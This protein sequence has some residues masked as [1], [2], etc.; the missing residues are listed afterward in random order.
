M[1]S[2]ILP[3]VTCLPL[4]LSATITYNWN[5]TW[6]S[7]APDG[8]TRPVI[9]INNQWPCPTLEA[10]VGDT[11]IVNLYNDLGNETT[12]LHFHGLFMK[13][14]PQMDGPVGVTQCSIMPGTLFKYEFKVC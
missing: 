9:G 10:T 12:G 2:L 5:V 3:L 8:F 11:V 1:F 13:N 14:T 6:V 4:A 7:A